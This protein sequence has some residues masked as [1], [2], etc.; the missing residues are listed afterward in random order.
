MA[1][2]KNCNRCN[3]PKR[4]LGSKFKD[5][6]GYCNCGRPPKIVEGVAGGVLDKLEEGFMCGMND[7]QACA[8]A[9]ISRE[10]LYEYQRQNPKFADRKVQL[11]QMTTVHAKKTIAKSIQGGEDINN[12]K[13]WLEKKDPDFGNKLKIDHSLDN[14]DPLEGM[15]EEEKQALVQLR[16]ARRRRIQEQTQNYE[17][18]ETENK[19][20]E[21]TDLG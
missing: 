20:G 13:W 10:T 7:L 19:I 12:S 6:Q 14:K 8:Y 3:K 16:E 5:A 9:G 18:N 21:A 15:N 11:R 17:E 4:P 1:R 2:P